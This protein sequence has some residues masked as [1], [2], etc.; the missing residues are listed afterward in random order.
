MANSKENVV[1]IIDSVGEVL[2]SDNTLKAIG[3][4]INVTNSTW[5]ITLKTQ[6]G[7]TFFQS[8]SDSPSTIIAKPIPLTAG[9]ECTELTACSMRIYYEA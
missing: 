2:E 3:F 9:I 8:S 4:N 6:A 7:L 1:L 5:S